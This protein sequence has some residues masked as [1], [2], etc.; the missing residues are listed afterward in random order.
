MD[1]IEDR[2]DDTVELGS[3]TQETKG[4]PGINHDT[5]GSLPGGGLS[6]D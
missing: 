1:R 6:H 2:D 5:V 4:P 3:V